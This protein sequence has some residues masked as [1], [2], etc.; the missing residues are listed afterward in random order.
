MDITKQIITEGKYALGRPLGYEGENG[1]VEVTELTLPF[2]N[3]RG[4]DIV[5]AQEEFEALEGAADVLE[6][7]KR[8]HAYLIAK[9][10][11]VPYDA[12]LDGLAVHDFSTLTLTVYRFLLRGV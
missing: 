1:P 2:S 11:R 8:F 7:S 4:R 12:I 9:M 6:T 3:L 10:A 5:E